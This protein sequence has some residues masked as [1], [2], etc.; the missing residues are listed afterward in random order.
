MLEK[1]SKFPV[2]IETVGGR[3]R[4]TLVEDEL[5]EVEAALEIFSRKK[6]FVAKE[7]REDPED[8]GIDTGVAVWDRARRAVN[9]KASTTSL[10]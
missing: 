5:R 10:R 2:V 4:K 9:R 8:E 1:L 3:R 7:R 6:V